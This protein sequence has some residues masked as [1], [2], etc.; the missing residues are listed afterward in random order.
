MWL[1]CSKW[2]ASGLVETV[3]IINC[4]VMNIGSLRIKGAQGTNVFIMTIW[5]G[6]VWSTLFIPVMTDQ[7]LTE[8]S[9]QSLEA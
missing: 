4:F 7:T 2:P 1:L 9:L 3:R 5:K 8:A 6:T